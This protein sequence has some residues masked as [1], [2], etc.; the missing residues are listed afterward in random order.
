M[1]SNEEAKLQ[2]KQKLISYSLTK[3]FSIRKNIYIYQK[4]L[5]S[6]ILL[7]FFVSL[8]KTGWKWLMHH[9]MD[10]TLTL[11]LLLS[12]LPHNTVIILLFGDSSWQLLLMALT[13][14]TLFLPDNQLL[15]LPSFTPH[16]VLLCLSLVVW[17]LWL[18]P[19]PKPR[20]LLSSRWTATPWQPLHCYL[21][22]G[23]VLLSSPCF[24]T[25]AVLLQ[26]PPLCCCLSLVVHSLFFA[27]V[28]CHCHHHCCCC[29]LYYRHCQC[30]WHLHK[31]V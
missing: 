25:C 28:V 14:A 20:M 4:N 24:A 23:C 11:P 1:P 17:W 29:L 3:A 21:V 30:R 16:M 19:P 6:G 5:N 8:Q 9:A 22:S 12:P 18:I 2:V 7:Q 13:T 15:P 27:D 31:R 26:L 10:S